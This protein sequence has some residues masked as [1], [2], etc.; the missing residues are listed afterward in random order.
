[1]LIGTFVKN[2]QGAVMTGVGISVITASLSGIFA[3]YS[4]LPSVLQCFSRIYP[5]SS[6]NSSIVYLL[7]GENLAG[8]NPLSVGQIALT[9]ITSFSL[10]I[11]GLIAYSKICWRKR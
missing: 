10:F 7:E 6:A 5:I 9:L 11:A 2:V 1:M 3:P 8:Y 4:V